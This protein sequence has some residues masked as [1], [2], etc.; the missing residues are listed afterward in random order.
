[1]AQRG[2]A[3]SIFETG[4]ERFVSFR[5]SKLKINSGVRTLL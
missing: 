5:V 3:G 2:F 1:M 4:A